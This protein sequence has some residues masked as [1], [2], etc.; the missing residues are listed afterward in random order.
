MKKKNILL[1]I[2]NGFDLELGLKTSYKDFIE[3]NMYACYS[4][5]I[6]VSLE[7]KKTFDLK[8]DIDINIF[9]YFKDILSIQNWIDLEMEIGKLASRNM[10]TVNR[11]TGR[12]EKRLAVSSDFMMSSFNFLRDCLNNYIST[13]KV[14]DNMPNNYALQLM[15]I[16][17]TKKYD[18]VRIV[19]FNYTD[20]KETTRFDIQV[21]VYHI[22]GKISESP[23]TNL[24]LGIQD[25]V[26]VDKS[27]SY[28]I[29]SHSPYYHSSRII[30]MLDEA[31]EV[32]F[33]GHSLGE[34]DYPYF[35]DFFQ[36]QCRK[37]APENRKKIRIFT[38]NEK[39]RLDILF[40][41]RI[42]NDK[43]TRLFFE[44]SDFALYRTEDKIDDIKIQNYFNELISDL[45]YH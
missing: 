34:T 32:I 23:N 18:N 38:Y 37:I 11:Q 15:S 45:S 17:G 9:K 5:K 13:L 12:Y 31:D 19:T 2:G 22:H 8:Y 29:K 25:S 20:L 4:K 43:Q 28:V 14:P 1:I 7:P 27:F 39:S 16:L 33:F 21:P 41:L 40:Q 24:I 30:D 35:S 36:M 26:E 6:S 44:N 42:M 10:E 3:S